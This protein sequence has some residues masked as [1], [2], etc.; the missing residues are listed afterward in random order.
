MYRRCRGNGN[1]YWRLQEYPKAWGNRLQALLCGLTASWFGGTLM[2]NQMDQGWL[3]I[4]RRGREE[5]TN[6]R[7][8]GI[9]H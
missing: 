5:A 1:R 8:N 2:V 3:S 6:V 4:C 7:V 9:E